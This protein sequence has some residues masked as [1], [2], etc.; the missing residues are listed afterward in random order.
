[1]IIETKDAEN[2][3]SDRVVSPQSDGEEFNSLRP[4]TLA[5]F[6]GQEKVKTNLGV[7]IT[8]AKNRKE[9]LDH[10][11]LAGP[12]G[13]GKTTLS[14]I[15]ANELGTKVRVTTGPSIEKAGDLAAVLTH[16][17]PFDVLFI[18]EIH[19]LPRTIEEILYP[20]MEDFKLDL[21]IGEGPS[22]RSLRIDLP[23]FTLVGAT[24]RSGLLSSP[25]RS[26]FGIPLYLDFYSNE[27]LS[28]IVRRSAKILEIE[29]EDGAAQE[30]AKRARKTPRVAN[31]LLKRVRDFSETAGKKSIEQKIAQYGLDQLEVDALGCDPMD[32]KFLNLIIDQFNG[33]P[34]GIETLAASLQE[35]RDTLEDIYEPYL[36]QA[37]FI[38]RTPR[39]RVATDAAYS[40]LQKKRLGEFQG[41]LFS[42]GATSA[43]TIKES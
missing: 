25:L 38:A 35:E 1:M 11:L 10:V 17:E 16:L 22:A 13:L 12:P 41:G 30:I 14:H 15:I 4:Q 33:G 5:D 2:L 6:V 26:R 43:E 27:E 7:F 8:A 9:A 29:I 20:A 32:R 39:G 40:H 18:D 21:M 34:V 3:D 37:G 24:T 23:P 42:T 28:T 19:R 31:R 36:L